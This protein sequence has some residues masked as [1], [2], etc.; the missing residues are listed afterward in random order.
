MSA[1]VELAKTALGDNDPRVASAK[2]VAED[3]AGITDADRC[4]AAAKIFAC[5]IEAGKKH[6]FD[7]AVL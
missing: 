7:F 4:E 3:C 2:A 5:S 1:A 6:G